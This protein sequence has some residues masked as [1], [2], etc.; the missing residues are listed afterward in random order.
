LTIA[1][2][3]VAGLASTVPTGGTAVVAI[4]A[5]P[6]GGFITNPASATETLFVDP[7]GN[8]ATL[9]AG[10]TCFGLAPGQTWSVI[11]GQTTSTSVNAASNGH[12]FSSVV[13]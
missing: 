1:V 3:P 9:T 2:T 12:T 8:A 10:G 6:N 4:G 7:T 5:N 11:P 13:W